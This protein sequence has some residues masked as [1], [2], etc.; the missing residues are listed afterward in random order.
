LSDCISED[1]C[2]LR[3]S[4][5]EILVG[6]WSHHVPDNLAAFFG[7]LI[8]SDLDTD[9]LT[10]LFPLNVEIGI[11]DLLFVNLSQ[12]SL[13]NKSFKYFLSLVHQS[14]L[15]RGHET[16]LA[17]KNLII[18][19]HWVRYNVSLDNVILASIHIH[20]K[21]SQQEKTEDAD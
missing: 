12:D 6:T 2:H 10:K 11:I 1:L 19:R 16:A 14:Q 21:E 9:V 8:H 13:G 17:D 3:S 18:L 15:H 4:A 7:S 20:N 5:F